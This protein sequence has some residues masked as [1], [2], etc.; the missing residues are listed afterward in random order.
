MVFDTLLSDQICRNFPAI[1]VF[2]QKFSD[3]FSQS[4]SPESDVV[5]N[6]L[7]SGRSACI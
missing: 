2:H 3:L 5:S 7:V 4:F 6:A 1:F